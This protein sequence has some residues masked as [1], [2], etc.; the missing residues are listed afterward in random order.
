MLPVLLVGAGALVAGG[1]AIYKYAT[2]DKNPQPK[3][4]SKSLGTF[5]IWG[6]PNVGKTTFIARLRGLDPAPKDKRASTSRTEYLDVAL[7][8]VASGDFVIDKIVDMPGTEDRLKDWLEM[9]ATE[10]H[11]FY[12]ID[13]SR[14]T[15]A[16]YISRVKLDVAETVKALGE[17]SKK[18]KRIN[19]IASH[20]DE[21]KWG[22][23]KD[24][25]QL[26]NLLQADPEIRALYESLDDVSGYIYSGD[27]TDKDSFQRLLQGVVNDCTA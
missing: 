3:T 5:V 13:L 23:S 15:E 11:V 16:A 22:A 8:G 10:S 18:R 1:V 20:V 21:S 24:N 6:R 19:I 2:K 27:L 4:V 7:K 25:P 14:L 12:M 9:V 17:S 26:H